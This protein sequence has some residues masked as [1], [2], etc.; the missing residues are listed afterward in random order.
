[1]TFLRRI[2]PLVL[3]LTMCLGAVA[4]SAAAGAA[5]YDKEDAKE[6][7]ADLRSYLR[8]EKGVGKS[9]IMLSE[10]EAV[11]VFTYLQK[12][13][14]EEDKA[15]VDEEP[16]YLSVLTFSADMRY[17]YRLDLILD[18]TNPETATRRFKYSDRHL[19]RN[20]LI[21]EDTL[22]IPHYTG[23]ELMAFDKVEYPEPETRGEAE[24]GEP[25]TSGPIPAHTHLQNT[26]RDMLNLAVITL[27]SFMDQLL[28]HDRRDFGFVSY[29]EKNNPVNGTPS[30][31]LP[32]TDPSHATLCADGSILPVAAFFTADGLTDTT[33]E[34][35]A[36]TDTGSVAETEDPLGPAFSGE[37]IAYALRM[38]LLGIGMVFAVLAILWGIL[39]IFKVVFSGGEK[40]PKASKKKADSEAVPAAPAAPAASADTDP[41]VV[42]AIT[43]AIAEMIASDEALSEQ[44]AGGFRV[45]EFKRKSGK[46]SWNH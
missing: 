29:N 12:P 45:V 22:S 11:Q 28:K 26:A 34:T 2:L 27:D 35:V 31:A 6:S 39:A 14:T 7:V 21:A 1:M 25:E 46:T 20:L 19:G 24:T 36:D 4:C 10:N 17:S 42:A 44:F 41:A 13:Q 16:L 23:A 18:K 40:K 33:A 43:A 5:A 9:L 30:A 8:E 15:K 37:R 32:V 38:T 3:L